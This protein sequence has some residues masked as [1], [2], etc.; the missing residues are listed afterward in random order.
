MPPQPSKFSS[1]SPIYSAGDTFRIKGTYTEKLHLYIVLC[2]QTGDPPDFIAVPLNTVTTQTDKTV[3]L[4]PIDHPFITHETSVSYDFLHLFKT[5]QLAQLE[6]MNASSSEV[7]YQR[8]EPMRAE[9]LARVIG[10]ALA[11]DMAPKGMVRELRRRLS[12]VS[13]S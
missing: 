8:R 5:E 13:A 2:D 7:T 6:Q 11:S 12:L 10:G 1:A 4:Q 3:L 9:V